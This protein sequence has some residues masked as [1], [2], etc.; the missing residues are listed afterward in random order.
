MAKAVV[1]FKLNKGTFVYYSEV[2]LVVNALEEAVLSCEYVM[3]YESLFARDQVGSVA[4]LDVQERV[5]TSYKGLLMNLASY[6]KMRIT[7][8]K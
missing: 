2:D 6:Q 8:E 5:R 3:G 4:Y 1:D 7:T